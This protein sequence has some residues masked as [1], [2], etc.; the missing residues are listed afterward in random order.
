MAISAQTDGV[1]GSIVREPCDRVTQQA[2][3]AL[4]MIADAITGG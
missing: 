2:R 4:V 1:A 3:G